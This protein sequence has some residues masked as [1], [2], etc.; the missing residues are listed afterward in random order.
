MIITRIVTLLAMLLLPS[1]GK[2]YS[3][4]SE[5]FHS[6]MDEEEPDYSWYYTGRNFKTL[7][8][9]HAY[10]LNVTSLK[11]FNESVYTVKGGSPVWT[12]EVVV[13]VPKD[14]VYRNVSTLYMASLAAGCNSDKPINGINFDLEMAD[15]FAY[16]TKSIGVAS[17]QTPNCPMIFEDDPSKMERDEDP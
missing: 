9:S 11:W 8:G 15:I 6:Y 16:D 14:L 1:Y 10:V 12:H 17:F 3:D 4:L 13:V 5:P 2:N 7:S